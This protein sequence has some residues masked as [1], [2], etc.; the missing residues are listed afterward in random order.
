MAF[1]LKGGQ[2][3]P[4]C[5]QTFLGTSLKYHLKACARQARAQLVTCSSCKRPVRKDDLPEHLV[6]CKRMRMAEGV[7][8]IDDAEKVWQDKS[9]SLQ[10][11]LAKIEAGE[12]GSLDSRGCFVCSICGQQGLGLL[13]IVE[14]EEVCRQRLSQEGHVSAA[15]VCSP[16]LPA[17]EGVQLTRA[18]VAKELNL[19]KTE[20]AQEAAGDE[21]S[22]TLLTLT[23]DRLRDVARNACF[24]EE[25]KY[26]RLRL[27]NPA[28]SEAIGRWDAAKRILQALGFELV[29]HASK[30]GAS[31]EP[32]LMLPG[33]LS[34]SVLQEFL[35][36]LEGKK[37]VETSEPNDSGS[38][39]EECK[40]CHR[41]FRFD[42]IAK[43][44]TR[45]P[46]SKP[47]PAKLDV[48]R[49]LLQGTPG[50]QNIPAARQDFLSG[51]KL[52]PLPVKPTEP[53]SSTDVTACQYSQSRRT[54]PRHAASMPLESTPR[55]TPSTPREGSGT[56]PRQQSRNVRRGGAA[57][58]ASG[59]ASRASSRES[60]SRD[61]KTEVTALTALGRAAKDRLAR[62]SR[63]IKDVVAQ[64]SYD[65]LEVDVSNWL[66]D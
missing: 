13:Q 15:S 4:I 27:S 9:M 38:L 1:A 59:R 24:L 23:L 5:S 10:T 63:S 65:Q 57:S 66:D 37:E 33:Q 42:R 28:V 26:R 44:E 8:G 46:E 53:F 43:H 54:T 34:S 12:I 32:H 39:L 16:T 55:H 45:C 36:A 18:A 21:E 56:T 29:A 61:A 41:K 50:E 6:R 20:I 2:C 17:E 40:Y 31:P 58:V 3:C 22:R 48:V 64:P 25:K 19:L 35:D 62:A 49:K 60:F 47:K 11:A 7:P 52:P 30:A 14:H 51:K